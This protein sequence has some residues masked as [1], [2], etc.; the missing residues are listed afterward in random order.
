MIYKVPPQLLHNPAIHSRTLTQKQQK[1]QQK[2]I[3]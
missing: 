2:Q 3:E 1:Q